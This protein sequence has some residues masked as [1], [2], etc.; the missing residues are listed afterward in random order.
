MWAREYRPK[1][2]EDM[3]GNEAARLA[4]VKWLTHWINGSKPLLLIGPPGTGK[5]SL[6]HAL[7]QQFN[8]DLIEMNASDTRARDDLEKRIIP[9]LNNT[10]IFRKPM[11]LFLDEIDGISSRHDTGGLEYLTKILKEPTI[12]VIIA[13]NSKNTKIKELAKVCRP[14]E[15]KIIPPRLLLLFLEHILRIENKKLSLEEKISVASDCRGDIRSLLNIAQS[16]LAG[17]N[18]TKGDTT[19]IDIGNTINGYFSSG[20]VEKGKSFLSRTN[21]MYADPRFGMSTEERRKDLIN[22]FFSSIVS[23]SRQVDKKSM[24]A[25]LDLLSQA[26]MIV[27]KA[28]RNRHWSILKYLNDIISYGLYEYSHN[29]GIKYSQ[30]GMIWP[31][32]GPILARGQSMKIV[33]SSLAQMAHLSRSTFGADYL[34]YLIKI[35]IDNKVDPIEFALISNIDEKVGEVLAKE[36]GRILIKKN[37]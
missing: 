33:L 24:A 5:T 11:L 7:A 35:M 19:E 16:R 31:V 26:D 32:M 14:I 15:Y 23:S 13:A 25:L 29:K 6:V 27:G 36:M 34:P 22:A 9:I 28:G 12:P 4:I 8:Y 1:K 17:Y 10:S 3:I 18:A 30:Y 2:V 37:R 21:G 20:S